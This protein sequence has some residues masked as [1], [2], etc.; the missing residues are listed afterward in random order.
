M[1]IEK[2]MVQ[3]EGINISGFPSIEVFIYLLTPQMEKLKEPAID[4]IQDV[5]M[6]LEILACSIIEKIFA[7]FPQLKPEI[8][9]LVTSVL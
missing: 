7:R 4:L 2:A 5:Y 3:M 9:E 1:A 8:I 6:Q